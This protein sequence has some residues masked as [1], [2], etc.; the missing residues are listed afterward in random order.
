MN[1]NKRKNTVFISKALLFACSIKKY[2]MWAIF[3]TF[4][5]VKAGDLATCL[6]VQV[7]GHVEH[8]KDP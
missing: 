3:K 2:S 8:P 5:E 4:S 1:M 7:W 6:T